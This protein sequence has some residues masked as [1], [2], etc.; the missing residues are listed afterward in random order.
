MILRVCA[1]E[2]SIVFFMFSS[3]CLGSVIMLNK[4]MSKGRPKPP[5]LMTSRRLECGA[6]PWFAMRV[7]WAGSAWLPVGEMLSYHVKPAALAL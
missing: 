4:V 2:T 5:K 7:A 1:L 3:K 6:S